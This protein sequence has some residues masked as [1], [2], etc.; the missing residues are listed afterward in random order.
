MAVVIKR[1]YQTVSLI[2]NVSSALSREHRPLWLC[3]WC[4]V[5]SLACARLWKLLRAASLPWE[6]QPWIL[7]MHLVNVCQFSWSPL[8]TPITAF[9]EPI[10]SSHTS[11]HPEKTLPR[12]STDCFPRP[13]HIIC[14]SVLCA[15]S[16]QLGL[17]GLLLCISFH[18][19]LWFPLM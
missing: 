12:H 17:R 18:S 3:T 6:K 13:P 2:W 1:P 15:S 7:L 9:K 16:Q 11:R 8:S 10:A 14:A 5:S 19:C 4:A